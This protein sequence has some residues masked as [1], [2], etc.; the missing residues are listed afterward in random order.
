MAIAAMGLLAIV[1]AIADAY[2]TR[3]INAFHASMPTAEAS[4]PTI[5]VLPF[6][7]LSASKDD[8]YFSD[9]MTDQVIGDLSEIT[10]LKVAAPTSSFMFKG[11]NETADKIADALHVRNLL[12]GSVRRNANRLRIEVALIDARSGFTIW[13][14]RYDRD[15][16][17]IFAIQSD[18]AENV[19]EKLKVSLL[20]EESARVRKKPTE[21]QEAYDLYLQGIFAASR[22]SE[23]DDQK[24]I[25]YLNRAI[26]ADPNFAKAHAVLAIIYANSTDWYFAPR[27]AM[28]IAK[29]E[30]ERALALDNELPEPHLALALYQLQFEWNW[31]LAEREY[32][33]AI[34]LALASAGPHGNYGFALG[35]MGRYD[36]SLRELQRAID[37]DPLAIYWFAFAGDMCAE[38]RDYAQ[39]LRF[40]QHEIA[41]APQSWVGYFDRGRLFA[42]EGNLPAAIKEIERSAA[43]TDNPMVKAVL[44][45]LYAGAGRRADAL[46]ILEQMREASKHRFVSP[47]FFA[48]LY[49][50]LGDKDQ[51]F[52]FF[53]EAYQG[54]STLLSQLREPG[55]DSMRSDPR[56]KALEKK[57]GL[58]N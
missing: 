14:E 34:E 40:Y 52:R 12:E 32:K 37:L 47:V 1:I 51:A 18:V 28:P 19:A 53:D 46:K 49:W 55:F 43:L 50:S 48:G 36:D 22:F 10:G 39:A 15:T 4:T 3:L 38:R 2:R 58:Y 7:N 8:E 13:S 25:G 26:A 6:S 42:D 9:G 35:F 24:A 30:A 41:M 44:G 33:R 23:E 20:P 57:I 56:F 29:A 54:R 31:P 17:D 21:N 5:A 27:Q 45:P 16:T 11:R